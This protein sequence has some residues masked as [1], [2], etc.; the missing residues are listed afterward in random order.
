MLLPFPDPDHTHLSS[1]SITSAG[2][3]QRVPEP[4]TADEIE[5]LAKTMN[6][7]LARLDDAARRQHRFVADASHELR[8]PLAAIR[9]TLEVG[10]A[11]PGQAPWPVIA[12][13]AVQQAAR[14]DD[15]IQELLLL[16]KAD[17]RQLA[18]ERQPVDVGQL[19]RDIRASAV[20][21]RQDLSLDLD[22]APD[23][24]TVGNP[25]HVER[26]FRN[27]IDNALRFALARVVIRAASAA[28][29][30]QVEVIDDG[31][32]IPAA[33]RDRVF[34]RFVRLDTSRERR[35]GTAGLGLAIAR[36]IAV[37]HSGQI[38]VA[39]TNG[40]GAR[41]VITLPRATAD[42]HDQPQGPANSRAPRDQ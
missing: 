12:D 39:D 9:T 42:S 17:E 4:G 15:L 8:S 34:D 29:T 24:I 16:A 14:L 33:E 23:V 37:A 13:R 2:T 36:E 3:S 6:D 41:I 30:V 7:M 27:I 11:H 25:D 1:V 18:A 28:T 5:L 21:S 19:L 22:V 31:P 35:T 40:A 10:L 20:Q 38:I 32:G 26:L